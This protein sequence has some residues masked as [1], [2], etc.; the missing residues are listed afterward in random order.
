MLNL[1]NLHIW[2]FYTCYNWLISS[3]SDDICAKMINKSK[4]SIY[5]KNNQNFDFI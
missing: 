1:I 3:V 5:F 2:F 4:F